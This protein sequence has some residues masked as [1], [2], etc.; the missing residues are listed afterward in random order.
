MKAERI[1]EM[2]PSIQYAMLCD[3]YGKLDKFIGYGN[4]SPHEDWCECYYDAIGAATDL[5][6]GNYNETYEVHTLYVSFASM[7]EFY[8]LCRVYGKLHHVRLKDNPYV[9]EAFNFVFNAMDFSSNGGYAVYLQTKINHQW[10][11]GLVIRT[12]ANY[13]YEEFEL[14]EAIFEVGAWYER[15]LLRLRKTLLEEYAFW[16]PALPEHRKEE[17]GE[18]QERIGVTA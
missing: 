6:D 3:S 1:L 13:F 18:T 11:S 2:L 8:R 4:K 17:S 7:V 10:A 5:F 15:A 9:R 12:D 14:V 16:L